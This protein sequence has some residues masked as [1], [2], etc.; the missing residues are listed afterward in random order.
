MTNSTATL[1]AATGRSGMLARCAAV[2]IVGLVAIA[3]SSVLM[4]HELLGWGVGVLVL[5]P[6]C[7][8]DRW[9]PL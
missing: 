5:G 2:A 1:L 4:S 8:S 6:R 7:W 9:C 3:I